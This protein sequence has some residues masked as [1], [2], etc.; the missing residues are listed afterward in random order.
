MRRILVHRG[1]ELYFI[2][3]KSSNVNP[4]PIHRLI[5]SIEVIWLYIPR[6]YFQ[7]KNP[8]KDYLVGSYKNLHRCYS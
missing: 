3:Y 1:G 2:A 6:G 7:R 8:E 4:F 5:E